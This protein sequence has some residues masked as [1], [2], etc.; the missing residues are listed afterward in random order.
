MAPKKCS[1]LFP[2]PFF[3]RLAALELAK[4]RRSGGGGSFHQWAAA[5]FLFYLSM[6]AAKCDDAM[7]GSFMNLNW[8]WIEWICVW[9]ERGVEGQ[10]EEMWT[11]ELGDIIK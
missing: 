11:R 1:R 3:M 2:F 4:W 5:A 10:K 7:I 6:N 9:A 8:I